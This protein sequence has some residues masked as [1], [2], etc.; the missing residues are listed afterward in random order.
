MAVKFKLASKAKRVKGQ[1][2]PYDGP[3]ITRNGIY[4]ARL[5]QLK[6]LK[7]NSGNYGFAIVAEL[8]AAA[9]DPKK[10]A[11]FDGMPFFPNQVLTG[12]A[13]GSPLK[14]GS[15]NT[16][17]NFL[18]AIGAKENPEVVCEDG[19]P[20]DGPIVVKSIGGKNPIGALLNLDIQMKLY[21]GELRPEVN[22]I[23][24]C[25]DEPSS[26]KSAPLPK[27]AK[28]EDDEDDLMDP[29]DEMDENEEFEERQEELNG[30]K[31]A[32]LRKIAGDD[33]DLETKGLKKSELIEA[34][35][36]EEFPS[37]SAAA[38]DDDEDE[39]D[40]EDDEDYDEDDEDEEDEEED[41]RVDEKTRRKELKKLSR[42]KLK[43]I[44]MEL[45]E[46]A[47]VKKS[48]DEKDLLERIIDL[49]YGD[50]DDEDDEIPF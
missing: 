49:E 26:K 20:D 16:L 46:D 10:H 47:R 36:E 44:L 32:E 37:D 22:S 8:E 24:P 7:R 45:D 2:E 35:L 18:V 38:L 15:Q 31:I 21:N 33:L 28:D 42:P 48:E 50:D 3:E 13:D 29:D 30:M 19:D 40:E 4:R 9:G 34:I 11:Q 27:P 39:A 43:A 17:D 5:K 23:L 1:Y 6:Y 25:E 12:T 14:E 41:D